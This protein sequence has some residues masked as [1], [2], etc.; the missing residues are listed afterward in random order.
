[1]TRI[2]YNVLINRLNGLESEG[3]RRFP[4]TVVNKKASPEGARSKTLPKKIHGLKGQDGEQK[5][6]NNIDIVRAYPYN[7]AMI[8]L[9]EFKCT[10]CGHKWI[11]RTRKPK[12]CP[13]CNSPYWDKNKWKGVKKNG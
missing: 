10:R 12:Y 3:G 13:G 8:K 2:K 5:I 9:P 11:P 1:M 6:K 4:A 7:K